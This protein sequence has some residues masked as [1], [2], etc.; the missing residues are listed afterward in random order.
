MG[1]DVFAHRRSRLSSHLFLFAFAQL[2]PEIPP[3]IR[4]SDNL[5]LRLE[6][7]ECDGHPSLEADDAQA[8]QYIVRAMSASR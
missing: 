7:A 5:N 6:H 1:F 4:D 8:G 3:A 2:A